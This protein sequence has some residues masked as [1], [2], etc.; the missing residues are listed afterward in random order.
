MQINY[1]NGHDLSNFILKYLDDNGVKQAFICKKLGVSSST[2]SI[3]LK[4]GLSLSSFKNIC[5]V[6]GLDVSILVDIQARNLA[7]GQEQ[8]TLHE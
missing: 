6:L 4:R 8:T 1:N 7:L 2:L 5:S 3:N